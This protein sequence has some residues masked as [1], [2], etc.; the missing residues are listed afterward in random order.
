VI[1]PIYRDDAARSQV[2]AYCQQLKKELTNQVYAGRVVEVEI[3]DRDLRGGEKKWYHVKRGVPLSIEVG[4]KDIANKAVFLSRRDSGEK[5]SLPKAQ[6]VATFTAL[7]DQIQSGLFDRALKLRQD[8]TVE[9]DNV[10]DFRSYFTPTNTED[11][12]I[13]GGFA[14]CYFASE[15]A[16]QPLLNELK[17]TI[18]CIPLHD[19]DQP[20][21]CF[22]TGKPADKKAVFA[23]A[24]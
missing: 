5:S 9:I 11:Q 3:D 15:D 24:Y 13:H 10:E 19:N 14:S 4:P 8:N 2:L 17:A 16:V 7:L 1:L 18:R 20:G 21:T 23:K 12:Q 22:L 6:L